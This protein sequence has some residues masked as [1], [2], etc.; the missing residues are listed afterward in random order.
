MYD[1]DEP[2]AALIRLL[3]AQPAKTSQ[4]AQKAG[5]SLEISAEDGRL[6]VSTPSSKSHGGEEGIPSD[7][8]L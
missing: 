1:L 8:G 5:P 7:D 4:P 6:D 2:K 3:L